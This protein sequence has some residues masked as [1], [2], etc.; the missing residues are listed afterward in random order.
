MATMSVT[1]HVGRDSELKNLAGDN[2]V[3]SWSMAYDTGYGEKKKSHW[4][5]CSLFGKRAATLSRMILKGSLVE[6]VGE[7][8]VGVWKD[9]SGEPRGQIEMT[10]MEVKFHGGRAKSDAPSPRQET[11]DSEVPF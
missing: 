11:D 8:V 10:V 3:L 9:R 5:K 4:V 6:V 7:P 2:Q 1:G